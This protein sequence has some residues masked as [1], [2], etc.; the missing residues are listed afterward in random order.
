MCNALLYTRAEH[1]RVFLQFMQDMVCTTSPLYCIWSI[2]S[3]LILCVTD[4]VRVCFEC[5]CVHVGQSVYKPVFCGYSIDP[6][7]MKPPVYDQIAPYQINIKWFNTC[8][9]QFFTNIFFSVW[10]CGKN[11]SGCQQF[12]IEM[13]FQVVVNCILISIWMVSWHRNSNVFSVHQ[14]LLF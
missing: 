12:L 2:P 10:K 6:Q 13:L 11:C 4:Y 3:N 8:S 14:A 1:W 5:V 9:P 7:S